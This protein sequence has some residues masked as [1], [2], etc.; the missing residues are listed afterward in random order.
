MIYEKPRL[1]GLG[2]ST[3]RGGVD[4]VPTGGTAADKCQAGGAASAGDCDT[5]GSAGVCKTGTAPGLCS[6]GS[7]G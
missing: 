6:A 7:G 3:A 2:S 5:G 1:I 4:C